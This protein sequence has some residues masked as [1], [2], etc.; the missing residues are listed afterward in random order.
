MQDLVR[1]T[2]FEKTVKFPIINGVVGYVE[3]FEAGFRSQNQPD[4]IKAIED[5]LELMKKGQLIPV[6]HL[7][8]MEIAAIAIMGAKNTHNPEP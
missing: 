5:R 4:L 7:L 1:K 2:Q 3:S 6:K 8:W